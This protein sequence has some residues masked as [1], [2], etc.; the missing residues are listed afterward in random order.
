MSSDEANEP[1][2]IMAFILDMARGLMQMIFSAED[3][4]PLDITDTDEA[5]HMGDTEWDAADQ[6]DARWLK[7]DLT[8]DITMVPYI[9]ERT[10][11]VLAKVNITTTF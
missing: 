4:V 10:S 6:V 7:A 5:K 1:S 9:G 8:E 3:A 11:A 2:F